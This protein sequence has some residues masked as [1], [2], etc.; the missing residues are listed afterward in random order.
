MRALGILLIVSALIAIPPTLC[1][2][3]SIVPV[4][5]DVLDKILAHERAEMESLRQ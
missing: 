5:G 1:A 2:Q 3:K 4:Q